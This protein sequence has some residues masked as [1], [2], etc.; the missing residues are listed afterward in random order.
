MNKHS[1]PVASMAVNFS[2]VSSNVVM[3]LIMN[4]IENWNDIL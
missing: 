1:I 2:I 4:Q 3:H